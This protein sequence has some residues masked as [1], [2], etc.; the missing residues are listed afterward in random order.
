MLNF[1]IQSKS[2]FQEV[3]LTNVV[4]DRT[5]KKSWQFIVKFVEKLAGICIN[6][7]YFYD[8]EPRDHIMSY[9][10]HGLSDFQKLMGV[11]FISSSLVAW[12]S[13]ASPIIRKLSIPRLELLGTEA[14]A[15]RCSK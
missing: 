10:F 14:A 1:T 11:V 2:L 3:F 7:C 6:R 12:K 13:R 8:V 9:Q 4:W 15:Q 5:I